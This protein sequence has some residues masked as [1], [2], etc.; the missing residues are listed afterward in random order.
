MP[1]SVLI[2]ETA[3]APP[4]SAARAHA[5]TS[6]VFGVSLT[7]IGLAVRGRTVRTTRSSSAGTAPMSSPVFTFGH[8]TLSS[9]AAT[10]SRSPTAST[11]APSSSAVDPMTLVMSG[12]GSS[13]SFGRS[14]RR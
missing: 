9:T 12:T 11:S 7:T 3:S 14:S 4:A 10:A 2:S 1:R 5:G 8:E 6:A 13:A